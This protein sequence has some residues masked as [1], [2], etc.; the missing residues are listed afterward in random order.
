MFR[1]ISAFIAI[2]ILNASAAHAEDLKIGCMPKD[3]LK[4]QVQMLGL[5]FLDQYQRKAPT[6]EIKT[7]VLGTY[8][9]KA[10]I[11]QGRGYIVESHADKVC[12]I[13]RTKQE[14]KTGDRKLTVST[15]HDFDDMELTSE[16][17]Q[18]L[19]K[20]AKSNKEKIHADWKK[21]GYSDAEIQKGMKVIDI[22]QR[23]G[24]ALEGVSAKFI[25]EILPNGSIQVLER[26][27]F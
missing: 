25:Y 4:S 17:W 16:E 22:M 10:F 15:V 5:G 23:S 24:G 1:F 21:K 2:G 12:I 7:S 9:G 20:Y 19:G 8:D 6:G 11:D 13:A 14:Y 18:R 27:T 26:S 3:Q